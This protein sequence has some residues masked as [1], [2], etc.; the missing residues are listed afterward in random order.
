MDDVGFHKMYCLF[1]VLV[2]FAKNM[3]V[4]KHEN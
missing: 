2:W 4:K 1:Y 3:Q